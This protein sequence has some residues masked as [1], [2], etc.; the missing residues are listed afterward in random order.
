M[1]IFGAVADH[2]RRMF[3]DAHDPSARLMHAT[4]DGEI[5]GTMRLSLGADVERED[6]DKTIVGV[7]KR[8]QRYRLTPDGPERIASRVRARYM[9]PEQ[10]R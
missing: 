8:V 10:D 9:L 1:Q 7:Q 3:I 4:V 6:G 2:A 5:A